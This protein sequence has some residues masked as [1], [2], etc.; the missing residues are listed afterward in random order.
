MLRSNTLHLNLIKLK[1]FLRIR[2]ILYTIDLSSQAQIR[3]EHCKPF[4]FPRN[5]A[6]NLQYLDDILLEISNLICISLT[7]YR[8]IL[9]KLMDKVLQ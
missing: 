3:R 2:S 4:L 1:K 7:L 8:K 9:N 5:C 6:I